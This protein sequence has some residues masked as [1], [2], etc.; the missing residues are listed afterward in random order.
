MG[1]FVGL[2]AAITFST[3]QSKKISSNIFRSGFKTKYPI[4]YADSVFIYIR[5]SGSALDLE[6]KQFTLAG[7]AETRLP[8]LFLL[9]NLNSTLLRI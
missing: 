5:E 6:K 4:R 9:K 7:V 1:S 3:E 8:K 2:V